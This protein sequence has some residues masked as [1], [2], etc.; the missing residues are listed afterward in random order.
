VTGILKGKTALVTGGSRGV[1]RVFVER[2]AASGALV[3]FNYA[4]NTQ[5]AAD[6]VAA[7]ES[8]GGKAF[9]IQAELGA[10][11]SIEG[12]VQELDAELGRRT[13][14]TGLDI[15]VNNIGGGEP[16]RIETVSSE[17]LD[18]TFTTNVRIPFLLTQALMPRLRDGGR[19]VNISSDTVRVGF[20]EAPAYVMCKAALDTFSR[21]LAKDLGPRGIDR[22]PY[23]L[24]GRVRHRDRYRTQ[25]DAADG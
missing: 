8:N 11:G 2:L 24:C 19:V 20:E 17:L 15:L 3:A 9:A 10:E 23:G 14:E 1:G 4:T 25:S 21:L 7:I 13:G 12:L 18:R 6:T 16:A 5:A 22:A